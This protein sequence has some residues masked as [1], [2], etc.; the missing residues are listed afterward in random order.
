MPANVGSLGGLGR[1]GAKVGGGFNNLEGGPAGKSRSK[2]IS[3]F[4]GLILKGVEVGRK[5]HALLNV[6]I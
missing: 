1:G 2:P 4:P 5:N 3:N 6:K